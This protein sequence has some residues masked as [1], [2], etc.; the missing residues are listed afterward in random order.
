MSN[1]VESFRR[2]TKNFT[3]VGLSLG[4]LAAGGL[5]AGCGTTISLEKA[6]KKAATRYDRVF[7][8]SSAA[9]RYLIQYLRVTKVAELQHKGLDDGGVANK[10]EFD[11]G[12]ACLQGT[13]YDIS[14]GSV[15]ASA[16]AG[17]LFGSASSSAEGSVP[18]AAAYA[19]LDQDNPNL[20]LIRS[21]HTDSVDLH[22]TNAQGPDRMV[23][24]DA[25]TENILKTYGCEKSPSI[26]H[27][28]FEIGD[29]AETSPYIK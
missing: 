28:Y 19:E 1:T 6:Q 17:G 5:G 4:V 7:N 26:K 8:R 3:K 9:G 21:G 25:S 10:Y 18:T 11:F 13:A 20:L 15:T 12:D 14:G 23:P 29:Y 22:F 2:N 24:A 27:T 16:R